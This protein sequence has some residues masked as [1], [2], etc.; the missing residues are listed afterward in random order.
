MRKAVQNVPLRPYSLLGKPGPIDKFNC[1][2]WADA[3]RQEYNKLA[4]DPKVKCECKK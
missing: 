3:V 2:D 1:Q 4:N